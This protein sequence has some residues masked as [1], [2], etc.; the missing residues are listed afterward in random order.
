MIGTAFAPAQDEIRKRQSEL[1]K[2]RE[3]IR[4]FEVKIKEQQQNEQEALELLDTYDRKGDLLR[5]LIS[6]LRSEEQVLQ[7]RIE[8][9]RTGMAKLESQMGFLRAHYA[10]YMISVYKSGRVHDL[11]LL[12]SSA[13]L[14]QFT[15][16]NEYL[17]RFSAQRKKDADKIIAKK[18]EIGETQ[19]RLQQQLGEERRLIAEKA[20]EEDRLASLAADRREVLQQIRKD[21]N[22]TQQAIERQTKAARALEN[23]LVELIEAERIKKARKADEARKLKLPQPEPVAGQFH[24]KKGKLR[25]PVGEGTVVARFGNQKHPTLKTITLNLGIDIAVK[26]GSPV[27]AVAEGEVT[28]ILWLPSY[29]N[30]LIINHYGGYWT[31]YTHLAEIDVVEGQKVKEG[32]VIATSGEGLDGPRIH[33]EIWKDREKQNPEQWLSRQ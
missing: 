2:I 22:L 13:S 31:V 23:I 17:K 33:F 15:I 6:K 18:E 3:R 24:L 16:R 7:R 9:T 10:R 26:A 19:A 32:D 1:D 4:Q 14:N 27:S 12:L 28:K 11:E 5:E 20:T 25:W 29:G 30:L 8:Q 21:K